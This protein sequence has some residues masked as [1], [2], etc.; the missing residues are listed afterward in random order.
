MTITGNEWHAGHVAVTTETSKQRKQAAP[1]SR[2]AAGDDGALVLPWWRNPINMV[3]I[4]IAIALVFGALGYTIASHRSE[5]RGSKVDIGF[6]QDMRVHHENAVTIARVYLGTPT[7]D[8]SGATSN[9]TL[10]QIA[11]DV[12]LG[13]QQETGRMIQLLRMMGAAEAADL[14]L[15]AMTWMGESIPYDRMPGIATDD[16]INQLAGLSGPAADQL[17]ASL[18]IAHHQ[19]GI[20]MAQY[21][22]DH[23]S[24]SEATALA[25]SMITGQQNDIF[26]MSRLGFT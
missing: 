5:V 22:V 6:L 13:Q 11:V 15:P 8:A 24:N 17:F 21:E 20:H 23:G 2:S 18:M 7:T 3:A 9:A 26:D 25:Q 12:E 1:T 14:D 16:Q 10:R 4:G 19:A